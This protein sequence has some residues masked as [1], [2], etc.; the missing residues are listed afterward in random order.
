M[1]RKE[2]KDDPNMVIGT[3]F[4][5]PQPI[6]V[7]FDSDATYSFMS[8]K[9]VETLGLLPTRRPPLLSVTLPDEKIVKCDEPMRVV[10]FGCMNTSFWQTYISLS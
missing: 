9:L 4:I 6:Y 2:V 5:Q 1:R 8:V 10:P 3:F 7:L